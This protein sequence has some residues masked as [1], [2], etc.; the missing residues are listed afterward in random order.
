MR[1]WIVLL[2]ILAAVFQLCY[3]KSKGFLSYKI[4]SAL[5][6]S[7]R[8]ANPP[9][10]QEE[11]SDLRKSLD[12]PF[13]YIGKGAQSFAFVSKDGN[14]V[15]KLFRFDHLR[16]PLLFNCFNF[17][18]TWQRAKLVRSW[19][20]RKQLEQEFVSYEL[21]FSCLKEESGLIYKHLNKSYDLKKTVTLYDNAHIPHWIDLDQVEF[22]LQKKAN[23]VYPTLTALLKEGNKE[24]VQE[25]FLSLRSI[26]CKPRMK[27]L[28][29]KDPEINK[30][31]GFIG[32]QAI[33]ID[34]G[35][36]YPQPTTMGIEDIEKE[37]DRILEPLYRFLKEQEHPI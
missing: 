1:K 19:H 23:L 28:F 22:I 21:A 13:Y 8:F 35:R 31:F 18:F 17:P 24:K 14:V 36:F 12:Q 6:P 10:T 20:K 25:A 29:D 16:P 2:V 3:V 34:T 37:A 11:L 4:E 26:L 15:L 27:G 33:Q 9:L 32:T 7:P 5:T 30:N